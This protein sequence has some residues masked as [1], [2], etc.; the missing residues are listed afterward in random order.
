MT[1]IRDSLA[2]TIT[3][4]FGVGMGIMILGLVACLF[5]REIPLRKSNHGPK[6]APAAPKAPGAAE[7]GG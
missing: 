4:L 1:V 7:S 5:L 6:G 2:S 3:D